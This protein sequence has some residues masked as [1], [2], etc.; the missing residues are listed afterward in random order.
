MK[1]EDINGV[2]ARL[3]SMIEWSQQKESRLGYFA[4]T[5]RKVSL[6]VRRGIETNLF[7]DGERMNRIGTVFANRYFTAF[8]QYQAGDRPSR[9]WLL[10]FEAASHWKPTVTQHLILGMNA[11]I[12]LDLGIAV[13]RTVPADSLQDARDDFNRINDILAR[14]IDEVQDQL[15]EIWPLSK[16]LDRVGGRKDEFLIN[17]SLTKA[18]NAAWRVAQR[19]VRLNDAGQGAAIARLDADVE[20]IGKL[21]LHPGLKL[22]ATLALV[23]LG[24]RGAIPAVIEIL[25]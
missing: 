7:D 16:R 15:A 18:R 22:T 24:E 17:F 3:D 21:V 14:L 9:A 23:R 5:Y 10:S 11:H 4:A 19:F 1:V 13:A 6:E 25:K 2:I 12:N 20:K 8:D